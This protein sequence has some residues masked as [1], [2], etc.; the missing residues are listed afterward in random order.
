MGNGRMAPA[1]QPAPLRRGL[2]HPCAGAKPF[3]RGDRQARPALTR[4]VARAPG[5][6][7][8]RLHAAPLVGTRWRCAL[9]KFRE[10]SGTLHGDFSCCGMTPRAVGRR[11]TGFL[12]LADL[13][14]GVER[15]S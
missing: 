15:R 5:M 3:S 8:V 9:P 1:D 10:T 2:A 12:G 6:A 4:R 14:L 11:S 13:G 7:R